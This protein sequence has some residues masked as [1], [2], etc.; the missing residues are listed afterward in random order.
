MK[1]GKP[2]ERFDFSV[3][4]NPLDGL[5]RNMDSDLK[6]RVDLIGT[7]N[8]IDEARRF[9]LLHIMFRFAAN[10]YHA[11]GF[12]LSDVDIHPK[13]LPRFVVVVP[14]INR[15]IMD[16]WF[17][18]VYIMDDFGFRELAFSQ[19][20]YRELCEQM[21][22]RK[23]QYGTA[24]EWQDWFQDMAELKDLMEKQI[25][26]TPEEKANP[27]VIP[28]WPG[29]FTLT[30]KPT[31]SQ[32]FLKFLNDLVYHDTSAHAHLKPGGLF[33]SSSILISEFGSEEQRKLIEDRVIHQ[34]KSQHFCR[35]VTTL[36]GIASEIEAYCRMKN[37][38][39]LTKIWSL[40]AGYSADAKDVF[41]MRYRTMLQLSG[42]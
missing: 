2:L 30:K 25:P 33:A 36:L 39:Q 14:P 21:E 31:K 32:P 27:S 19:C 35:T 13:R 1:V 9:M 15:Q 23:K 6:R 20:G 40:L 12:L 3:V 26:L 10:S 28:Y 4:K 22:M 38:E 5:I 11:V 7:T 29:P 8:D 18:L 34:F 37:H 16:L 24:P 17:S 42:I 41:E